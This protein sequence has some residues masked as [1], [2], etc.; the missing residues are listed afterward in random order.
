MNG[1]QTGT[2]PTA[3]PTRINFFRP[4]SAFMRSEVL[5]IWIALC[6]WALATFGFQVLLFWT[7]TDGDGS[8]ALTSTTVFGFPF[9]FWFSGQFLIVWFILLCFFFNVL[10]DRLT[11]RHRRRH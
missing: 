4:R 9:H 3:P 11:E 7:Q 10:V 5:F 8:S 6:G 2:P 1:Q